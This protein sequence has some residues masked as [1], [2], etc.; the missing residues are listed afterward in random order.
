MKERI[1]NLS[2]IELGVGPRGEYYLFITS[3]TLQEKTVIPLQ[4]SHASNSH[5]QILDAWIE[6]QLKTQSAD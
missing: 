1:R 2:G 5:R 4:A 6:E 3:E